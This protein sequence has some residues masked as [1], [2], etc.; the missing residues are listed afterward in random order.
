MRSRWASSSDQ[1]HFRRSLRSKRCER[2]CARRSGFCRAWPQA[3]FSGA[4]TRIHWLSEPLVDGWVCANDYVL[5]LVLP[6]FVFH[7]AL[8]G[9]SCAH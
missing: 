9:G 8:R 5:Q 6:D 3:G 4:E 1:R 7:P 2:D